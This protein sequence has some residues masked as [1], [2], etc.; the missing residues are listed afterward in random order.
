[1][2][3]IKRARILAGMTQTEVAAKLGVSSVAVHQWETGRS[4]PKVNRLKSVAEILHTTV[5]DL[6]EERA[7]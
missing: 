7:V 1:M 4:K 3:S 2:N 6:L 5:E